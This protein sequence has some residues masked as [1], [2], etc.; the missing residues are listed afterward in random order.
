[1]KKPIATITPAANNP[2]ISIEANSPPKP[3]CE[4]SSAESSL[5]A[6]PV[7]GLIHE[8]AGA[9][10][11]APAAGAVA[12]VDALSGAAWRYVPIDLLE[13]KRLAASAS[14]ATVKIPRETLHNPL[15]FVR[16]T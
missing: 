14:K 9:A 8:R 4:A 5:A 6:I 3:R 13:P 2:T 15:S 11:A 1:M 7:T 16:N 12:A 10:A